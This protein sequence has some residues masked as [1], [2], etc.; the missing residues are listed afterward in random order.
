MPMMNPWP[1]RLLILNR[2]LLAVLVLQP[3]VFRL[4]FSATSP[5]PVEPRG[6]L[7]DTE[8]STIELFQRVRLPSCRSWDASPM[9]ACS[10][11]IPKASI[12]DRLHLGSSR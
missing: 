5:R 12:R 9:P 2:G 6:E 10:L 8:K 4:M 7:A 3:Y 1:V 11:R